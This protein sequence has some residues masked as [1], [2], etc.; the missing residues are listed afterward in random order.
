MRKYAVSAPDVVFP[1]PKQLPLISTVWVALASKAPTVAISGVHAGGGV[2][3]TTGGGD[4]V[5]TGGGDVVSTGGGVVV[6]TGGGVVVSTGAGDVLS[7][8]AGD[9]DWL[10]GEEGEDGGVIR[11]GDG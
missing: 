4:V 3:V 5:I 9:E 11:V 7:T 1:A 10:V 2:V 8:G 6:S